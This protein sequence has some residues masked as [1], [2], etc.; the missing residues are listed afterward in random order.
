M[1][2]FDH[3]P[4]FHVAGVVIRAARPEAAGFLRQPLAGNFLHGGM[5]LAID[6]S[7]QARACCFRAAGEAKEIPCRKICFTKRTVDSILHLASAR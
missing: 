3:A 4:I 6:L 1:Q 5:H 7:I 2:F